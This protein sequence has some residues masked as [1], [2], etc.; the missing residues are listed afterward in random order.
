MITTLFILVWLIVGAASFAITTILVDKRDI[1]VSDLGIVILGAA[2]GPISLLIL[3]AVFG[4]I[5]IDYIV[6]NYGDV[7][8][9]K[10]KTNIDK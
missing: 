9:I 7:V 2:F 1:V 8:L 5:L 10:R 3:I 6:E 4:G